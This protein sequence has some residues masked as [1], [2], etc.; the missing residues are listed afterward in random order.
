M[1][2]FKKC[3]EKYGDY[4][5]FVFRV[6][7]GLL[8]LQHGLQK[9]FGYLGGMDGAGQ[10]AGIV[11]LMGLAGII[12]VVVGLAV[13]FGLFTRLAG[14]GGALFMLVAYFMV[15]WPKGWIPFNS[16]PGNGGELALLYLAAFLVLKIHGA[17]K[18]SLEQAWLKKETF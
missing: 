11:S 17:G 15:H 18:W 12:E 7:V 1:G 5:Y 16:P 6:L 3:N 9:L 10:V 2:K 4:A 13:T 14:A 8:F